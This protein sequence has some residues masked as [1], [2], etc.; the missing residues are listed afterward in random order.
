MSLYSDSQHAGA[1]SVLSAV[2]RLGQESAIP[3]LVPLVRQS[4]EDSPLGTCVE[5][6]SADVHEAELQGQSSLALLE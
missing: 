6:G 5:V 4:H 1:S 2:H 3:L